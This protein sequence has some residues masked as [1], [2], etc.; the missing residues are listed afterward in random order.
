MKQRLESLDAL[1]GMDLL[2]L[3]AISDIIEELAEVVDTPWMSAIMECFTHKK[4]EG[5]SPWDLVMPLF[6]FMAGVA[7]PFALGKY[8]E[9]LAQTGESR[10][11]LYF[12][13]G[14]RVLLLWIFGMMVQ[15]N[16]M[17]LDP[18]RIYFFTNT[19]QAIAVGYFFS[20]IIYLHTSW[21]TQ[22]G[23]AVALLLTF[24]GAMEFI[25]IGGYGGGDYTP[26]GN[27][28]EGIDTM[29][30]G[31]FR[32]TAQIID[33]QVVV[34]ESYTYTW[35][36]SSLNFVVTV[37]SGVL[38]GQVLKSNR[39]KQTK[40]SSLL[41]AGIALVALGWTW[42]MVHP[43]IKHI[44]TGSMVFVS[45]G[46]C[47]LLMGLFYLWIDCMGH[48][49]HLTVLKVYGMNSITAYVVSHVI[50]FKS[51]SKSLFFGLEQYVGDY[52]QVIIQVS[53]VAILFIILYIMYRKKIFLRV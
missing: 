24:W 28:A 3:V 31:R 49:K 13:L 36:L 1:R 47:F 39:S 16:L 9:S 4:W 2:F 12:R 44:W 38:A 17:A 20:A 8:K 10:K 45:S 33:G 53:N 30:L 21:K 18:D 42:D 50:S 46:Y 6:M 48:N 22:I 32:D 29:V 23:I 34:K 41:I 25:T 35:I 26:H 14:K 51:I 52:Y 27:L 5:F 43:V 19:L 15:G 11:R 7:I 37:L 40:V